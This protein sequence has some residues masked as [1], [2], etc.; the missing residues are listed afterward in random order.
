[1]RIGR[2]VVALALAGLLL[3]AGP[4]AARQKRTLTLSV[5][6]FK[7]VYGQRLK[8]FGRLGGGSAGVRVLVYAQP[9]GSGKLTRTHVVTTG[10]NGRWS[11]YVRPGIG[12]AYVARAAGLLSRSVIVGVRPRVAIARLSER[13]LATHVAANRSFAGRTVELQ[14]RTRTHGWRTIART[15]L[16]RS[17]SAVFASR[18]LPR[19]DLELRVAMSVNQAGAGY[20][21]AIGRPFRL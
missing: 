15:T 3:A 8:L 17:S 14:R 11:V 18:L 4:A 16:G 19:P 5:S 1:M 10:R 6:A 13:R 20:L 12:T 9:F 21:A 2:V 7:V